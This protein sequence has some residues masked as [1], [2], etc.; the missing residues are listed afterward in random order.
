MAVGSHSVED[1][2]TLE[3]RGV[4]S[5]IKWDATSC[6]GQS[7]N[8]GNL[9]RMGFLQTTWYYPKISLFTW[10]LGL[11]FSRCM[12]I[13]G[14]WTHNMSNLKGFP[15]RPGIPV[16]HGR[17][18]RFQCSESLQGL[19]SESSPISN[20]IPRITSFSIHLTTDCQNL[21][22]K[23]DAWYVIPKVSGPSICMLILFLWKKS[24]RLTLELNLAWENLHWGDD[25]PL[26]HADFKVG[27]R[28][29]PWIVALVLSGYVYL[30]THLTATRG[31]LS[32]KFPIKI[33]NYWFFWQSR[34]HVMF[35][36]LTIFLKPFRILIFQPGVKKTTRFSMGFSGGTLGFSSHVKA[37]DRTASL[38]QNRSETP[39]Q[40]ELVWRDQDL[41]S[42]R[43]GCGLGFMMYLKDM[44]TY[45]KSFFRF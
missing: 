34:P 44:S 38:L 32:W 18:Q 9:C 15:G 24:F 40:P 31:N 43:K 12:M 37:M 30:T 25:V 23:R 7:R 16:F 36:I 2:R 26:T 19:T 28:S 8:L 3:A 22:P 6:G 1:D 10:C 41:T 27:F 17:N 29:K 14:T 11:F 20:G 13:L 42:R 35:F 4:G 33:F 39:E 5:W 21:T 45:S